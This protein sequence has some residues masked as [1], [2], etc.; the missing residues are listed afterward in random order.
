MFIENLQKDP[1]F[2][3]A[4]VITVVV[5]ICIHELAHGI[6]AIWCGDRTPIDE[7]HMTLNP[8]VHMGMFSVIT[9]LLAGIAWGA[10][11]INPS[12]MRGRYAEAL[13]AVAGPVSN[14]LLALL[15]LTVLGLWVRFDGILPK[16]TP[17]G[18]LQDLLGVF[19]IVNFNLALFNLSPVPPLDGSR[20]LENFSQAYRKVSESLST[21]GAS[22]LV[23]IIAFSVAGKVTG[24][25]AA[26]LG[27][28]WVQLIVGS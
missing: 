9:L 28:K 23:F 27:A 13:V 5:S 18:N 17:A 19:G 15:S 25:L 8:A 24:P 20:I 3:F 10:M 26:R 2:F 12:R 14:V 6:V 11:P 4:V 21:S 16:G 7:G 22:I 1:P